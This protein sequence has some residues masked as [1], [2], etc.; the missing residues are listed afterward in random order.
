MPS[1]APSHATARAEREGYPKSRETRARILA[2]ALAEASEI[3]LHKTSVARIAARAGVA[4]GSVNY[5][6]G[7]RD[8]LLRELMTQQIADLMLRLHAADADEG[9]DFFERQRAG[10]LAYLEHLR[11]H[12]AHLRLLD[13]IK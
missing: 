1:R 12:P 5:H 10:L 8:D 2:A 13:E 7:S 9:A 6:F 4:L 11:A 3:G